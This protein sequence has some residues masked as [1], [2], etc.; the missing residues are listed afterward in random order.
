[1]PPEAVDSAVDPQTGFMSVEA[2]RIALGISEPPAA[3]PVTPNLPPDEGSQQAPPGQ[4]EEK[5][6]ATPE[7][8]STTS[9]EG[10]DEVDEDF[11]KKRLGFEEKPEEKLARLER[12]LKGQS[13]SAQKW[14]KKYK[15][16]TDAL[17]E[18]GSE[19]QFDESDTFLGLVPA[20]GAKASK[21]TFAKVKFT[22]MTDD[23]QD[24]FQTDPQDAIDLVVDRLKASATVALPTAERRQEPLDEEKEAAAIEYVKTRT[25]PEGDLFNPNLEDNMRHIRAQLDDPA[26]PAPLKDFY[27]QAPELALS[28]LNARVNS[29]RKIYRERATN[30]IKKPSGPS[31]PDLGPSTGGGSPTTGNADEGAR[32]GEAIA[33]SGPLW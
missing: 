26:A 27:R 23:E 18:Q 5:T 13:T 33:N 6:P 10:K 31:Q 32:I 9:P 19:P 15:A 4:G 17:K 7:P 22:D 16:L 24:L 29:E 20:K 21:P 28:L 2:E 30:S 25:D 1:M 14:S 11:L 3:P 8:D 12:D